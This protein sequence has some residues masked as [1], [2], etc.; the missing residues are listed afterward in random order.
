MIEASTVHFRVLGPLEVSREGT[1]VGISRPKQRL[2]LALLLLR[3]NEVVPVDALVEALWQRSIPETAGTALHG[4]VSQLRK[5]LG[6]G[7]LTTRAPGYCLQVAADELDLFEFERLAGEARRSVA[8]QE[9][10]RLLEDALALWRG[11]PLQEF[12]DHELLAP[13]LERLGEMRLVAVE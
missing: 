10:R 8:P 6:S 12:M 4:L 9:R 3:A 5:L 1:A 13:E 11:P 2:L 7:R